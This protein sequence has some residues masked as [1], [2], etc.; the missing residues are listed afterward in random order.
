MK[1]VF[2]IWV[3]YSLGHIIPLKAQVSDGKEI[4]AQEFRPHD[5][6]VSST[7]ENSGSPIFQFSPAFTLEREGFLCR[8]VNIASNGQN[9]LNDAAN[10]PSIA[11]NPLNPNEIM[12]GWRQFGDV[13]SDFRQAG[14]GYSQDGGRSWTF[15]GVIEPGVFRSD[16]VLGSDAQGN[17]YYSSLSAI[18]STEESRIY[19]SLFKTD[20]LGA[21]NEGTYAFGGDKQW[22]AIDQAPNEEANVYSYWSSFSDCEGNF[23]RSIDAGENFESCTEIG[24]SFVLWGTMDIGPDR[25]LYVAGFQF[26]ATE[27]GPDN[28]YLVFKSPNAWNKEKP[29]DWFP[30]GS[31][32]LGQSGEHFLS[33][34]PNP[35]GLQGQV[36]I[37][38]D[39]SGSDTNGNVYILSSVKTSSDSLD[40][41]FARSLDGGLTWEAPIRVNDDSA[42]NI[43]QWFGTMSVAPNGRIDVAWLDT[44]DNPGTFLSA[45]YYSFS[46]DGGETWSPNQKLTDAFDPHI[47]WPVQRKMGDYFDMVSDNE[48]AHLAWAGTFN[49]EQDVYYSYIQPAEL[50]THYKDIAEQ[51]DFQVFPNPFSDQVT[52]ETTLQEPV[53]IS[54]FNT[55][56]KLI[57]K[58]EFFQK[59]QLEAS[60]WTDGVYVIKMIGKDSSRGVKRMVK[61]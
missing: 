40:I 4:L 14:Y 6:E 38:V 57:Y 7:A 1:R 15:P 51:I 32:D 12:I 58:G 26:R 47:G 25:D 52:I 11:I 45:L 16:P 5:K 28:R 36:E 21:W 30:L 44:R 9:I 60:N 43:L 29:G 19:A 37:S 3:F 54:V 2:Y 10:E 17:F 61:K 59:F 39:R 55:V 23:T 53:H 20:S 41:M 48:G 33:D 8:Q 24:E 46:S 31:V 18:F 22:L 13:N 42:S 56:G 50:L 34:S 49:G 27:A 35:D